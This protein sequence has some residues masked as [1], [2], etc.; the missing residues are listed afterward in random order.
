M[1]QPDE[2]PPPGISNTFLVRG[3]L[4]LYNVSLGRVLNKQTPEHIEWEADGG[5]D[6]EGEDEATA[7]LQE[8]VTVNANGEARRRKTKGRS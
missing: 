6:G 4:F 7:A 1:I 2:V 8:A 5:Q 3:P